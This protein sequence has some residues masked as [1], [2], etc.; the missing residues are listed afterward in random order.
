MS[1]EDLINRLSEIITALQETSLLERQ[2]DDL[3]RQ[4]NALQT[5][6]AKLHTQHSEALAQVR[7]SQEAKAAVD[8]SIVEA[9]AEVAKLKARLF[10]E[11]A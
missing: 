4:V 2:R 6:V 11:A 3:Q 10:G 7:Y 8:Q 5:E 9:K 1:N